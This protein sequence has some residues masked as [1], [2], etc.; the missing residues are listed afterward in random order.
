MEESR[1]WFYI[2]IDGEEYK[3]ERIVQRDESILFIV[4]VGGQEYKLYKG[5]N[6]TWLGNTDPSLIA[7]LGKAIEDA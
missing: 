5:E 1:A 2:Q 7:K 6:D 4:F 3:V